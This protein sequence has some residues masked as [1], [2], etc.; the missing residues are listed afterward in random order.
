MNSHKSELIGQEAQVVA[1]SV[2]INQSPQGLM[3]YLGKFKVTF[4]WIVR[5]IDY[6]GPKNTPLYLENGGI[7]GYFPADF[8]A[9]FKKEACAELKGGKLISYLKKANKV[10]VVRE[11]LGVNGYTINPLKSV[12][13]D[14]EI[15]PL[16]SKLYIP[17]LTKLPNNQHNG[18]VYAHDI[19]SMITGNE[20]DIFVGYK[21]DC[22]LLTDAGIES[23]SLVDVYLLE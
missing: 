11:F 16:G 12:A 3:K 2:N 1:E 9:D 23:S 8:I 6:S 20:I 13:V 21:Q 22:K 4:Y 7:L 5:E 14:P 17:A 19:G 18:I 15:I 10:R